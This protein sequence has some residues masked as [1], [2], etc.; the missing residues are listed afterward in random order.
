LDCRYGPAQT[1]LP[2]WVSF[3]L[4]DL[5]LDRE[6]F[7]EI[8]SIANDELRQVRAALAQL[9]HYRFVYRR[10]YSQPKLLAIFGTKP[11][12]KR[13][14]LTVFLTACGIA[15]AWKTERGAFD[16]TFEAKKVVPWLI[17]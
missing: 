11:V 10:E 7:V 17:A 1:T 6:V 3:I 8:K 5:L 15:S 12:H 16:G 4:I 13:E 14:D 2:L 9:Y